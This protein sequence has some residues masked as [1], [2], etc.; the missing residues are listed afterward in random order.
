MRATRV[1][2]I[3][4]T[5]TDTQSAREEAIEQYREVFIAFDFRAIEPYAQRFKCVKVVAF[6]L[7][8]MAHKIQPFAAFGRSRRMYVK[9]RVCFYFS[10]EDN[11]EEVNVLYPRICP[12]GCVCIYTKFCR[13]FFHF[14]GALQCGMA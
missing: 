2:C 13:S 3:H 9:L 12:G 8:G 5:H 4:C 7:F 11:S 10:R 14:W 1:S 6:V